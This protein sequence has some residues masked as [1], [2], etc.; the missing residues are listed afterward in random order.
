MGA[1]TDWISNNR[2]VTGVVVGATLGAPFW[3]VG[4]IPGAIAGGVA[5]WWSAEEAE[6]RKVKSGYG[7]ISRY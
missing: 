6:K 1:V 3:G 5:G 4:A 7:L 2:V